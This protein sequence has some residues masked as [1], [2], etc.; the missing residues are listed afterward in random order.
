MKLEV[1]IEIVVHVVRVYGLEC[2][3]ASADGRWRIGRGRPNRTIP[4]QLH[5]RRKKTEMDKIAF[6]FPAIFRRFKPIRPLIEERDTPTSLAIKKTSF[7][8]WPGHD[9]FL[10]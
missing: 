8:L 10:G 2:A 4:S 9:M 7:S 1:I 3:V 6:K 5:L